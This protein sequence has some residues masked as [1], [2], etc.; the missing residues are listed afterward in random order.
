MFL[1]SPS[2]IFFAIIIQNIFL[3]CRVTIDKFHHLIIKPRITQYIIWYNRRYSIICPQFI[4]Q[5][6]QSKII[7]SLSELLAKE[8]HNCWFSL[9][10][11]TFLENAA[12]LHNPIVA[13][14]LPKIQR[15]RARIY[16]EF[17]LIFYSDLLKITYIC[18]DI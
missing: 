14:T 1:S 8:R 2:A 9:Q 11:V 13:A 17:S 7:Q 10:F 12:N 15:E 5:C 18:C 16:F 6:I 4:N 3:S